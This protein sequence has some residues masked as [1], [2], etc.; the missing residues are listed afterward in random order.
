MRTRI[1]ADEGARTTLFPDDPTSIRS[2]PG[3]S[4][5]RLRSI[6]PGQT[7]WVLNGPECVQNINWWLIAGYD[8]DGS[9]SGWIGEGENNTYWVEPYDTGP[10]A[11]PGAPAPRMVP[12]EG[13]RITLS[14]PLPSRV[15]SS[16]ER[17]SNNQIGQ[18]QPGESF[19]V[20]SGPVCD[21]ANHWRWWLVE[22]RKVEGWV[23]EGE[24]GQ[25]WMERWTYP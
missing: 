8:E 21:E 14:P 4:N 23:A 15:R 5:R 6:P 7:F 13:G 16:P 10:M 20:V 3:A 12:G 22:N 18:L 25:Y 19:E 24:I 1:E 17:L 9:W 2:A 11:C